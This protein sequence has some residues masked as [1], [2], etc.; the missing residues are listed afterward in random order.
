M[1]LKERFAVKLL[2][3]YVALGFIGT[4]VAM[5]ALCRPYNQYWAVP[6]NDIDQ[7]AFYR[8][9]SLPQAVFNISSDALMLAIPLPLLIRSR[10]PIKQKIAMV[11][12]F[13]MGLFVVCLHFLFKPRREHTPFIC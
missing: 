7:C 2:A 11:F 12:I 5:F 9:Y 8:K 6:P 10:L 1:G 13:S 3:G 4:E